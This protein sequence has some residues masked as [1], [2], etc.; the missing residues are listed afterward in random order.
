MIG[1][2]GVAIAALAGIVSGAPVVVAAL[3]SGDHH[4]PDVR[5][6]QPAHQEPDPADPGAVL[7]G[8][9]IPADVAPEPAPAPG[10]PTTGHCGVAAGAPPATATGPVLD[11]DRPA[12]V[13]SF[14]LVQPVSPT[15]AYAVD[16]TCESFRAAASTD[17]GRSWFETHGKLPEPGFSR[18]VFVTPAVGLA[19]NTV[20]YSGISARNDHA[21]ARTTDG[22]ASW[23]PVTAL[24]GYVLDLQAVDEDVW[25]LVGGLSAAEPVTLWQSPDA[26]ATWWPSA[27]QPPGLAWPAAATLARVDAATAYARLGPA[28]DGSGEA[29]LAVTVDGGA[30]WSSVPDPCPDTGRQQLA[31]TSP[32][33][34][35]AACGSGS[36]GPP[37]RTVSVHRSSDGGATWRVVA[38]S[39]P[40]AVGE[41][42]GDVHVGRL[43][44]GDGQRAWLALSGAP[45]HTGVFA[46]ADGG[47]TWR[48]AI[49]SDPDHATPTDVALDA[50]G[51]G[52]AL[53][54]G[55]VW[56][57]GGAG[58]S[59]V[60]RA[61][62]ADFAAVPPGVHPIDWGTSPGI[63]AALAEQGV[64]VR[65]TW[66]RHVSTL[67]EGRPVS[68]LLVFSDRPSP[69][70]PDALLGVLGASAGPPARLGGVLM[71]RFADEHGRAGLLWEESGFALVVQELPYSDVAAVERVAATL[72]EVARRRGLVPAPA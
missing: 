28:S 37:P 33:D 59:R 51:D 40:E 12:A 19:F 17:G 38:S 71:T 69:A 41:I 11:R 7:A 47:R 62:P 44:V 34:L 4:G 31:A 72:V 25:A 53:V 30:S 23:E 68:T 63:E 46:T 39:G 36:P 49:P 2:R 45:E 22:G 24:S 21:A 52:W 13:S 56:R 14:A 64:T 26:G 50:T 65:E 55:A 57:A 70:L 6:A 54:S 10:R 61:T 35:W 9:A 58:W 48:P 5:V 29:R 67:E 3:R 1:R 60:S 32:A 15:Q 18:L 20:T 43:A 66:W 16:V 42:P 8:P 27:A